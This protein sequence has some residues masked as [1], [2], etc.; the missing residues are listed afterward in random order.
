MVLLPKNRCNILMIVFML[1]VLGRVGPSLSKKYRITVMLSFKI[2]VFVPQYNRLMLYFN[3]HKC[4]RSKKF[5][6]D[7]KTTSTNGTKGNVRCH[8]SITLL[9][10]YL[11]VIWLFCLLIINCL[12]SC[13]CCSSSK[14]SSVYL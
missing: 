3:F 12:Y 9:V 1:N 4:C 8:K 11:L 13:L 7:Y 5:N 2:F 10:C 6:F 14:S